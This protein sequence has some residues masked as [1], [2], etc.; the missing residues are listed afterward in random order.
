VSA[1]VGPPSGQLHQQQALDDARRFLAR[2]GIEAEPLARVGGAA[3]EILA[4]AEQ[5]DRTS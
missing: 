2:R 3:G 1:A 4:A 5:V